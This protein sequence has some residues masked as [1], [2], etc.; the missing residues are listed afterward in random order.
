LSITR[1]FWRVLYRALDSGV[2]DGEKYS[3]GA[4]ESYIRANVF[5]FSDYPQYILPL[6]RIVFLRLVNLPFTAGT[7]RVRPHLNHF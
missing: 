7:N 3:R 6:R 5:G 1:L 4:A 2:L